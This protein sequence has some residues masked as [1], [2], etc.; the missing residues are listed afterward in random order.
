V[1]FEARSQDT[2][3]VALVRITQVFARAIR[4]SV[5]E[6]D[7][8]SPEALLAAGALNAFIL[9]LCEFEGFFLPSFRIWSRS[10]TLLATGF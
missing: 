8:A 6:K 4:F 5:K 2:G 7:E 10:S 1:R 3:L 9:P